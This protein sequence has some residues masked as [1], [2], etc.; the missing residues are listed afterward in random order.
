M[1]HSTEIVGLKCVVLSGSNI[2]NGVMSKWSFIITLELPV[3]Y[4]PFKHFLKLRTNTS[5]NPLNKSCIINVFLIDKIK[6][7]IQIF[8]EK[9]PA[10]YCHND[11]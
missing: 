3:L 2:C 8:F 7:L 5:L 4:N 6:F 11:W 1:H 10:S 9:V